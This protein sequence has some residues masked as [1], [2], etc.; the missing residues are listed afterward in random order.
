MSLKNKLVKLVFGVLLGASTSIPLSVW[1]Q[2]RLE[3]PADGNKL[4]GIG[5][6]RGW[7]CEPPANGLIQIVI[8]GSRTFDAPYGSERGDTQETCGDKDNGWGTTINFSSIGEGEHTITASADGEQFGAA[9]FNVG[10]PSEENFLRGAPGTFYQLSN[11]PEEGLSTVVTWQE[12]QQNFMIVQRPSGVLPM[13][14]TWTNQGDI[15][16]VCWQVSN[17][18]RLL[19]SDG[20]GCE[21]GSSLRL[22]ASG[23]TPGGLGCQVALDT[24]DEIEIT[25][26]QFAHV[27]R[28]TLSVDS[29]FSI[30]ARFDDQTNATGVAAEIS[31]SVNVCIVEFT[32]MLS[33]P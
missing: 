19:T 12:N 6:I 17:D 14:G 4:S 28:E 32:N 24:S 2:A 20:S 25:G 23:R 9:T 7:R 8:D 27:I 31:S 11:F 22:N 15:F 26:G 10:R 29:L 5:L 1:G 3:S 13:G 16:D 33:V 18:G 21:N 30:R